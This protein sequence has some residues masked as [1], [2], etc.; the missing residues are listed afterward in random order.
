MQKSHSPT[1]KTRLSLQLPRSSTLYSYLST[2]TPDNND[3]HKATQTC[4]SD[5]PTH[6]ADGRLG[7]LSLPINPLSATYTLSSSGLN[8]IPLGRTISSATRLTSPLVSFH[9]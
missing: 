2:S 7:S 4:R 1:A 6:M 3:Q 5:A 8:A 9:R